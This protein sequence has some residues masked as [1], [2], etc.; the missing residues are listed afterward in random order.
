MNEENRLIGINWNDKNDYLNNWSVIY[1]KSL[2]SILLLET[3]LSCLILIGDYFIFDSLTLIAII[4]KNS[5][6][7]Q[8]LIRALMDNISHM[9]IGVLS[10]LIISYPKLNANEIIATAFFSSIIDID[11][12]ISARSLKLTDAI[13]LSNRPFLHNSLTLLIVNLIIFILLNYFNSKANYWSTIFFISWFSHHIRDGNRRG[14]WLGS[15]H[16]TK[17]IKTEQYLIILLF[18]PLFLR[19][20]KQNS[21]NNLFLS[22]INNQAVKIESHIV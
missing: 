5:S 9:L 1:S 6:I 19:F 12:F 15:I 20:L 10:W 7:S 22:R 16:T 3:I 21:I 4:N 11:H 13:S 8:G 18:V 14:V 17:P 2:G